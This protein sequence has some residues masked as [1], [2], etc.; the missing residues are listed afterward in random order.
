RPED[1]TPFRNEA[2]TLLETAERRNS[3]DIFTEERDGA[4]IRAQETGD[5]AQQCALPRTVGTEQGSHLRWRNGDRHVAQDRRA[6]VPGDEPAHLECRCGR[7]D[8]SGRR[9]R[10]GGH[11]A[12]RWTSAGTP[13]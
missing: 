5:R 6:L 10:H 4:T 2:Q 3:R 8:F 1:A 11:S 9:R 13:V 12:A 7:G